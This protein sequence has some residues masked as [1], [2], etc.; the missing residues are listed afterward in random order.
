MINKKNISRNPGG[1]TCRG[2]V[3]YNICKHAGY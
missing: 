2:S 1:V 3:D